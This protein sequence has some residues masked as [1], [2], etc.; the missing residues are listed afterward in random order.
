ME[1]NFTSPLLLYCSVILVPILILLF[2]KPNKR[3]LTK[4]P[5]SPPGWPV[6]GHMFQLG[7]LPYVT[8]AKMKAKYGPVIWLKNGQVNTVVVQSANAAAEFYK[9]HDLS[10]PDRFIVDT[11]TSHNFHKSSFVFAPHGPYW[12]MLRRLCISSF[13]SKI[14]G[15]SVQVR[16]KCVYDMLSW[17]GKEAET[18]MIE[19][20]GIE[21]IDFVSL[22]NINVIGNILFSKDLVD[23]NSR[24][25]REL[26]EAVT[27]YFRWAGEPNVSD[28]LGWLKPFDLQ[29]LKRNMDKD[30]A[31]ALKIVSG[32][33]KE[34]LEEKQE[35]EKKQK[36]DLLDMLLDFEGNGIN[37]QEK[38][39]EHTISIFLLEMFLAGAETTTS[40]IEWTMAELLNN[41]KTLMK[42]KHE[43]LKVVGKNKRFEESDID[44]MPFLQAIVKENLRLHPP[45]PLVLRKATKDTSFMGYDIPKTTHVLIN[46]WAIGKD[47]ENWSDPLSFKP[48]R[49]LGSN[50]DY[51][52][53]YFEFV[54]F[55]SG[56]RLCP[57]LQ[58]AHRLL[59]LHL[60][61]LLHEFDWELED[62][63]PL[64]M[65]EK[66]G[67]TVR[68]LKPL[69]AIPTKS[70]F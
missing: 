21:I 35:G 37:E 54:P 1:Y 62:S 66:M 65:S 10:F 14:D 68:K 27:G 43:I 41:P 40:T 33:V 59:H 26:F 25:G 60:G 31:K 56:C 29:G 28:S 46:L 4:L 6:F 67:M 49:F 34:R 23:P 39:S 15:D 38:L 20:R 69:R 52:G 58:L 24:T 11:L 8:M 36:K 50:I 64:D 47:P 9:Y 55:G 19:K 22:A 70:C 51:K 16:R 7:T 17:I 13:N 61:S 5:P 12:R 2:L 53:K 48:E 18:A 32:F 63:S 57:G 44:N 3:S 45:G 30:L 42:A